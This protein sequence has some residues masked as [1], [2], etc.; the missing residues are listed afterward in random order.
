MADARRCRATRRDGEP[1]GGFGIAGSD[2]CFAHHPDVANRRAEARRR[3]G[4][5]AHS[6]PTL[7]HR[8]LR[9]KEP[10][11][12]LHLLRETAEA[13]RC[14]QL[15]VRIANCLAYLSQVSLRA[16]EAGELEERVAKLEG[17]VGGQQDTQGG[18]R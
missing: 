15:D 5:S 1:C 17:A 8:R 10:Q 14:G 11:D 2:L 12:V 4:A 16:M 3:G 7:P 9:L 6:V 18:R 13:V